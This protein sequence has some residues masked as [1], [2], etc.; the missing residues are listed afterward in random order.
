MFEQSAICDPDL[1]N[2]YSRPPTLPLY[3]SSA[4]LHEPLIRKS[5]ENGA[6]E[7]RN[8]SCSLLSWERQIDCDTRLLR[9]SVSLR[10]VQVREALAQRGNEPG[11]IATLFK[12]GLDDYAR[13]NVVKDL[14]TCVVAIVLVVVMLIMCGALPTERTNLLCNRFCVAAEGRV[15]DAGQLVSG[16]VL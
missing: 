10:E 1:S 8:R 16:S 2:A 5:V 12:R 11:N 4:P 3:L 14:V 13:G 9:S 15:E 6:S 7:T